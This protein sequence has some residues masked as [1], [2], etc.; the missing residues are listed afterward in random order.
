M[1]KH[2]EHL[3]AVLDRHLGAGEA[4]LTAYLSDA[5][6]PLEESLGRSIERLVD[7]YIALHKQDPVLHRRLS[8]EVPIPP[9]IEKRVT[10]LQK[11][12][13]ETV[14]TLLRLHP[15]ARVPSPELSAQLIVDVVNALTHR[16][17]IDPAGTPVEA[18]ELKNALILM[19]SQYVI[20]AP[21]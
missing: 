8:S 1:R 7:G 4:L 2:A 20:A 16:W 11:I 9:A 6:N 14:A 10:A 18:P 15:E 5:V 19:L 12:L 13:V 3:N 17:A 21:E